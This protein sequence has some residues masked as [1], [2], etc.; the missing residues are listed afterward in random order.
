MEKLGIIHRSS[1]PWASPLHMVEKKTPGTWR[2]CGDYRRLNKVTT[3]DWYPV[4]CLQHFGSQLKGKKIFSK[5]DLVHR[6]N[7]IPVAAANVPK[8]AV[9]MPFGLFEFLR[10]PFS[11]KNTAQ[12]FQRFMDQVCRGLED[13]LFV[14]IDDVL[15][16]SPDDKEHQRHL[17]LLF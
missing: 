16:A 9:I 2:P 7:Q 15:M 8:T 3:H 6:Y 14:Y 11:L 12:V 17:H 1:T 5:V 4:P 13:F 10:M